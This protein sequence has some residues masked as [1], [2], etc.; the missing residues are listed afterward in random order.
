MIIVSTIIRIR[1]G[2]SFLKRETVQ[3]LNA[4]AKVTPRTITIVFCTLLVTAS[5]EQIPRI[6]T[7]TGLFFPSGSVNVFRSL[8]LAIL[9]L[10]V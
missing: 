1:E 7:K 2:M 8:L 10:L 6:C 5:V 4:V 3:A 9:T